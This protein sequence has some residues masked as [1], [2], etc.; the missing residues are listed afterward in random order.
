M[1]ID[2]TEAFGLALDA[3]EVAKSVDTA[4]KGLPPKTERTAVHYA[5]AFGAAPGTPLYLTAA[6][7][8]KAEAERKD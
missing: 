5:V 2:G 8:D 3:L 6:L 4:I 7:I 1:P